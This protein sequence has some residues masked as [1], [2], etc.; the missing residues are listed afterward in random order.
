M[1]KLI[2]NSI[3]QFP[4]LL[5]ATIY[6]VRVGDDTTIENHQLYYYSLDPQL[7]QYYVHRL[8]DGLEIQ[9]NSTK[10]NL[11]PERLLILN[12]STDDAGQYIWRARSRYGYGNNMQLS[13]FHIYAV[14]EY[15]CLYIYIYIYA[16]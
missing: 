6:A 16:C 4:E 14:G 8:D 15:V 12:V 2:G 10:Y 1:V 11:T 9:T 7:E 13:E 3:Y 5:E